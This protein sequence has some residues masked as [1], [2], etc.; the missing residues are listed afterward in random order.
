[1]KKQLK[2]IR[3]IKVAELDV[4]IEQKEAIISRSIKSHEQGITALQKDLDLEK[5][6]RDAL[7]SLK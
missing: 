4:V 7:K 5:L 3:D 1:M 2:E 6:L